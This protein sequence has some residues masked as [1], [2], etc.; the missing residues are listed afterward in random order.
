MVYSTRRSKLDSF[1]IKERYLAEKNRDCPGFRYK[2]RQRKDLSIEE[3]EEIVRK[4]QVEHW[5]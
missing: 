3:I 1:L 4:C 2:K 5:T